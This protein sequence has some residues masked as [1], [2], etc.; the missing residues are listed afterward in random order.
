MVSTSQPRHQCLQNI[1]L[2]LHHA[3][4]MRKSQVIRSKKVKIYHKVKIYRW[5]KLF[6]KHSF[7]SLSIFY[8]NYN[9]IYML[10]QVLLQF[11][12]NNNG[13]AATSDVIMFFCPLLDD[14]ILCRIGVLRQETWSY[15][16]WFGKSSI[17]YTYHVSTSWCSQVWLYCSHWCTNQCIILQSYTTNY[18]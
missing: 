3:R 10:L 18:F 14:W 11:C 1:L 16:T 2:H 4:T 17:H 8:W 5:V 13:F 12:N 9:N 6:L 7:F 15:S